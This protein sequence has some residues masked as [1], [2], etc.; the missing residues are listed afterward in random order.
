MEERVA[1]TTLERARN[2]LFS[3]INRCGVLNAGEE[4]Q[5]QWMNETID[6][7]GERYPDLTDTDL[8]DLYTV[9]LRFC[10]PVLVNGAP[11]RAEARATPVDS[12][13]SAVA[14]GN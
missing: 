10:K 13:S 7:L 2:E 12:G 5:R 3:H 9:G 1:E 11:T 6:Y 8:R 4:D 14:T